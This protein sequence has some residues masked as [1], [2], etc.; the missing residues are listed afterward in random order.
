MKILAR[1]GWNKG[2]AS[3]DGKDHSCKQ[4]GTGYELFTCDNCTQHSYRTHTR[5]V[6]VHLQKADRQ[7]TEK[8]TGRFQESSGKYK[9]E[10]PHTITARSSKRT[11]M[12][13]T[14]NFKCRQRTVTRVSGAWRV[15]T[16]QVTQNTRGS[17]DE[18]TLPH[19]DLPTGVLKTLG[20]EH[21]TQKRPG[22]HIL[23]SQP[24]CC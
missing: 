7:L 18:N 4:G 24:Q 10:P 19:K 12:K 21:H 14:D 9:L 11:K 22:G 23:G 15:R 1:H 5:T 8:H 17:Y 6:C 13:K 2:C 3:R 20:H 16:G